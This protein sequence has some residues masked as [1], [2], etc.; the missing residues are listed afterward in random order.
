MS[1][2]AGAKVCSMCGQ[3]VS[4]KPRSKDAQG[5]Y[6]CAECMKGKAPAAKAAPKTEKAGSGE[7]NAFLLD[8]GGP[9]AAA[10][11][12][13]C[14]GC[15]RQLKVGA[16]ICTL[17]G[18]N[19]AEGRALK[20]RISKDKA[21]KEKGEKVKKEMGPFGKFFLGQ[22]LPV[23]IPCG[24]FLGTGNMTAFYVALGA[25]FILSLCAWVWTLKASLQEGLLH[26]VLT[27][28][29]WPWGVYIVFM[30][31]EDAGL[32]GFYAGSWAAGILLLVTMGVGQSMGLFPQASA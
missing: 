6:V 21:P 10:N 15:Q 8:L 3:D 4:G 13:L 5:R 28:F 14:P 16:K 27:F 22:V 18:F 26:A 29:F 11:V 1:E 24:L 25:L 20:T 7:D 17:C 9:S 30:K 32:K 23:G 2:Q 31:Q 19:V 12:E